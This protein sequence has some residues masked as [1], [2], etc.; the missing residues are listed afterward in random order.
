MLYLV[1]QRNPYIFFTQTRG[2]LFQK[3][4]IASKNSLL[5][6]WR[7]ITSSSQKQKLLNFD[8]SKTWKPFQLKTSNATLFS[9]NL[10]FLLFHR[11]IFSLITQIDV[12]FA[13][14]FSLLALQIFILHYYKITTLYFIFIRFLWYRRGF[15]QCNQ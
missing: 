8:H 10:S 4:T 6:I 13:I 14:Y 2:R 3:Q 12:R 5:T 1:L 15:K 9:S 11:H 7:W